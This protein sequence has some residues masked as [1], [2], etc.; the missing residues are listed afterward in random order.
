MELTSTTGIAI[1]DD[2]LNQIGNVCCNLV[3]VRDQMYDEG[4]NMSD[5]FKGSHAF[6]PEK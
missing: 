6:I 2:I 3:H 5:R 4:L 1:K